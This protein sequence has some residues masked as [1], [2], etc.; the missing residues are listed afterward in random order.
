M[1]DEKRLIREAQ[2]GS[3]KSFEQL[4]KIHYEKL[5]CFAVAIASG[6][7]EI[8]SDI[9][10]ESLIKAFLNISSFENRSSFSSWL[11]KIVR[12]E[13]YDFASK[14]RIET[15]ELDEERAAHDSFQSAQETEMITAERGKHLHCLIDSLP[16]HFKEI[17][18][19]IELSEISY[20]DASLLI[21]IPVGSIKSR[22]S[23]AREKLTELIDKNME[24]F[25]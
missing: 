1:A 13:F 7:K 25:R 23:R 16:E 12:N 15:E 11:W 19:I 22:L 9:L 24:L 2:Q 4:V 8:A 3:V 6:K 17:I 14:S 20:E 5:Y 18:Y 21:G 10:Q